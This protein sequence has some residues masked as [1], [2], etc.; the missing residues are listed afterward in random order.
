TK[1]FGPGASFFGVAASDGVTSLSVKLCQHGR[2]NY[3]R[4]WNGDWLPMN[5]TRV[6]D[7]CMQFTADDTTSPSISDLRGAFLAV[8]VDVNRPSAQL[9]AVTGPKAD[10][11]Y[12]S[13]MLTNTPV[14]VRINATDVTPGSQPRGIWYALDDK[15]C[16]PETPA[17]CTSLPWGSSVTIS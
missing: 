6:S 10:Q 15:T 13:N 7:L 8:G 3:M 12:T 9:T 1:R 16:Q 4:W 14:V 11:P 5:A 2:T 17:T